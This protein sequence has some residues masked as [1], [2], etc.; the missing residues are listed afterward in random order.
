MLSDGTNSFTWN[1]RNQVATLNNVSLQYDA[2]GRR[3]QNAAGTSFLYDGANAA[4]NL[5][6]GVVTAN[7]LSGGIDENFSRTDASGAS[8]PLTDAL[9]STVALVDSNGNIQTTYSY[10]PFGNTSAAGSSTTNVV[11]YTGRENEGNG[12]Y[13]YRARYYSPVLGRFISEDPLNFNGGSVNLYA[14]VRNDPTDLVDP[15]GENPACLVGGLLGTIGYNSYVIGQSL[16]GRYSEYYAGLSGLGHIAS[17]NLKAFGAGCAAGTL[18]APL[19]FGVPA[20][21]GVVYGGGYGAA[22]GVANAVASEGGLI[23]LGETLGGQITSYLASGAPDVLYDWFWDYA[24]AQYAS[25]LTGVVTVVQG[26]FGAGGAGAATSDLVSVE[27]PI[28]Y[29]LARSGV[30]DL[31]YVFVNW[32]GKVP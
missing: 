14:Y 4:Q 28:L 12:L 13:Y 21:A 2:R 7:L 32:V 10:D 8:A 22:A 23:P 9:G 29:N 27:L 17:G 3:I 6:G 19:T 15:S 26:S 30:V 24:S 25:G 20:G 1:A 11:Q 18:I 16:A 31:G 5:S